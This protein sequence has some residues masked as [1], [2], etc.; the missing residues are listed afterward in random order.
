[1]G[2]VSSVNVLRKPGKMRSILMT[3]KILISEALI[4]YYNFFCFWCDGVETWRS[5]LLNYITL[6]L[7]LPVGSQMHSRLLA[8]SVAKLLPFHCF[9]LVL[10]LLPDEKFKR[11][12]ESRNSTQT[13]IP[14]RTYQSQNW[15]QCVQSFGKSAEQSTLVLVCGFPDRSGLEMW[16][17]LNL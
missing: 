5:K 17:K 4:Q 2:R 13:T 7:C 8:Y 9:T 15:S 6:F 14:I 1:M 11:S 16:K 3:S 10:I 12:K